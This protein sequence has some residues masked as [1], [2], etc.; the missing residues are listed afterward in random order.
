MV[1]FIKKIFKIWTHK[2]QD[3]N[4]WLVSKSKK[5]RAYTSKG[6]WYNSLL[7]TVQAFWIRG[8]WGN[9][10]NQ[11]TMYI[12]T[13]LVVNCLNIKYDSHIMFGQLTTRYSYVFIFWCYIQICYMYFWFPWYPQFPRFPL[14]RIPITVHI[15]KCQYIRDGRTRLQHCQI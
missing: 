14:I 1:Q 8:K 10:G 13:Y 15:N 3:A 6:S 7:I 9:Q 2:H 11:I 5:N 4:P 12:N